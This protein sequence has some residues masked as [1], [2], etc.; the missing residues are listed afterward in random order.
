MSATKNGNLL[1]KE[2]SP[3]LL[4][5]ADNP[6]H[7]YSWGEAALAK[8]RAEQKPILLSIGY[9]ACHWCHVMAH[10]SFEDETTATV[11]NRLF[12]NIKVDREERPDLDVIYQGALSLMGEQGGWPLTMFCTPEG[13]PFWGGTYFPPR[14]G[15][16]RPGFPDLLEHIDKIYRNEREKVESNT[17]A[18]L[19]AL[20]EMT[21]PKPGVAPG[22][23]EITAL[24]NLLA[25]QVDARHGGFG[26]APKFPQCGVLQLIWAHGSNLA[27]AKVALTLDRMAQGGIYDHLGGG[28]AR[29][30][31]DAAW[32]VPHFE[33]MLYDNAQ[34]LTLYAQAW[35]RTRNPLYQ[36]RAEET[37]GWLLREMTHP[38]GGFYSTL[39][40][41]SDGAEGKFYVWSEAQ[42]DAA[43]GAGA[44]TF[45]AAYDVRPEGNW[46]GHNILNRSHNPAL[47]DEATE[48]QLAAARAALFEVR[49]PRVRPA[50]DD[51]ILTDWNG[52]MIGAL[53]EAAMTF[54]RPDWLDAADNAYRFVRKQL[55]TNLPDDTIELSHSW[56][57]TEA[58][59][60]ATLDDY[61]A[62]IT[63]AIALH[64][65]TGN[66][67]LLNDA[68]SLAAY[69][70]GHFAS[71][72]GA[73][74]FTSDLATDVIT[75]TRTG[76][77]NATPS[78]NSQLA[79]AL[80]R[81]YYLTGDQVYRD[82]AIRI[83]ESFAGELQ[84]NAF[85][86]GTLLRAAGLLAGVTQVAIIGDPE[87]RD[88][89]RLHRAAYRGSVPD[90]IVS[91]IT[92]GATLP[93]GHPAGGKSK[94]DGK[95]TA[96]VCRGPVCSPP[97]TDPNKLTGELSL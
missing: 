45:K 40:A 50:L 95:A 88:T 74:F 58:R 94:A 32:L 19:G 70:E 28:F 68:G 42:I 12:I 86:Y 47:K 35:R 5:H 92:P 90:R 10:E 11:M 56:R 21:H 37:V 18:I 52:L 3:Y 14:A 48:A 59:H 41:D 26:T 4:Q 79:V 31:T 61:A 13:K 77:D 51:K 2:T 66:F 96:Y 83:I 16:G 97:I 72:D 39:D 29:Y 69:V 55:S 93:E 43:L 27:K 6:V 81:M 71:N 8:A 33:K 75:R 24:A 25:D 38:N 46:D 7:W 67:E 73:Y 9:A 85:G 20:A 82:R 36:Q 49:A 30:S 53:V 80:T 76:L 87:E 22:P 62:L 57:G 89:L 44:A 63:A 60:L 84:E 65:A 64:E 78:G 15:F 17:G 23:E 1:A 34:L 54:A 91:V